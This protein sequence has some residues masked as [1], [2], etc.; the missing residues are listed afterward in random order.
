[1]AAFVLVSLGIPFRIECFF[2]MVNVIMGF[3]K[4]VFQTLCSLPLLGRLIEGG[5]T[6]DNKQKIKTVSF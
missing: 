3:Q 2:V 1:M 4:L 6:F 5:K